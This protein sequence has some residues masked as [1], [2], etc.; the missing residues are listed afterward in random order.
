MSPLIDLTGQTFGRLTVV[1]RA[2]GQKGWVCECS[3]GNRKA[4][5][6]DKLTSGKQKSCGCVSS[7][8]WLIDIT[9]QTF[10]H[11]TVLHQVPAPQHLSRKNKDSYWLCECIC[12]AEKAF[13]SDKLRN[14]ETKSC[15]CQQA[16]HGMSRTPEY[17]AW[18]H[19]HDRCRSPKSK[20]W[21]NYGGRGITVC[22]R[23]HKFENFLADMGKRPSAKHSID[24]W[25]SNDGNYEPSNCKWSTAKEQAQN[26]RS[27]QGTHCRRC[28][29]GYTPEN[30]HYAKNG[31]RSC[32]ECMRQRGSMNHA[33]KRLSHTPLILLNGIPPLIPW[34]SLPSRWPPTTI[35]AA[36]LAQKAWQF[37]RG[38]NGP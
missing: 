6:T 27:S 13:R 9:G 17:M 32:K 2:V 36:I 19:M 34:K 16:K 23:W 31:W 38:T 3:C 21:H 29:S 22:E 7:H 15:G 8:S 24:R 28:G 10:G 37:R 4:I 20:D 35:T 12:G 11:L 26:R 25:P 14:E 1:Q 30:S 5:R 18:R 33:A